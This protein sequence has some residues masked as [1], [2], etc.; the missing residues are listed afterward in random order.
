MSIC[1][2]LGQEKAVSG[3]VPLIEGRQ[4]LGVDSP[5]SFGFSSARGIPEISNMG[6]LY[7]CWGES[8]STVFLD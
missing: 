3:Q 2:P 1:R 8:K 7:F 6:Y 4:S 5:T